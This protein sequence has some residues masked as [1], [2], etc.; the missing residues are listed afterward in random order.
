M[1][2]P[3]ILV[4]HARLRTSIVMHKTRTF[5]SSIN[6]P[7]IFQEVDNK[8]IITLNRVKVLNTFT[9]EMVRMIY[10]KLKEWK[11]NKSL[12]IMKGKIKELIKFE[13]SSFIFFHFR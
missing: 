10:P 12:V 3:R 5:S 9:L 13:I 8:G 7:V 2:L 6:D 11:S 1:L 4:N